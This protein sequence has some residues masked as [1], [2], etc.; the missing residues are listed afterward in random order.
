MSP[1]EAEFRIWWFQDD[2]W[3]FGLFR[4]LPLVVVEVEALNTSSLLTGKRHGEGK[5]FVL[6]CAVQNS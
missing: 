4:S 1:F 2:S 5:G 6:F 3:P